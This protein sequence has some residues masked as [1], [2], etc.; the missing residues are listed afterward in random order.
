MET[1]TLATARA[2]T[3]V[4]RAL[5]RHHTGEANATLVAQAL[6][7]AEIDG[8]R[9]HGL[10]RTPAYAAQAASGKVDGHA[11][12]RVIRHASAA[13]R[14]DAGNGFAF[15][16]MARAVEALV[17]LTPKTGIAA[18]GVFRSHHSGQAGYHVERLAEQGLIGLLFGNSPHAIAPWGGHKGLFGTNPIAFAAPRQGEPPLL[19]DLSLSKVARGKVMVAAKEGRDIPKGWAL[20][21]DGHTTTDAQAALKGT[22]LPMGD[23]KGAV[24]VMMVEILAAT[25]T[26]ANH[27][28]EAGSFFDAEGEPPGVGQFL[29]AMD[30]KAFCGEAFAPRL[31]TLIAAVLDQPGTRLP[32]GGRMERR[33]NAKRD[34]IAVP[35]AL[36]DQLQALVV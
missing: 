15:P 29:M 2:E 36:Y 23:A 31:E 12:P 27:G 28:F 9:G 8:R 16:A 24:L 33:E 34:G 19:M 11:Q 14:V 3:L 32:G 35:V 6:V 25:L 30:P 26:G 4:T 20:N 18:A 10:S 7:A 13:L 5:V 17:A 21:A 22:M 1:V